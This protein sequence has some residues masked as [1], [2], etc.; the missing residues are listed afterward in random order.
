MTTWGEQLA[1]LKEIQRQLEEAPEESGRPR[2]SAHDVLRRT[3][4]AKLSES[5]G[6]ATI[7]YATSW[8]ESRP[9]P[10]NSALTINLGDIQGFMEAVS[11]IE[12]TELDLI[13]T[14]PGGSAEAAD[15][16]MGYLRT[17][18]DHIR[19]VVPVAAKSA[20]TMMALACDEIVMGEHSELGPID[21]QFTIATPE[22]PR[23]APA[24][25]IL[26]QFELAKQECRSGEN[27]A[28][29]LPLLRSL[30]PG[31]IAQCEHQR[32]LAE[33]FASTN[34]AT[35]MFAGR[36]DAVALAKETAAWFADFSA[37]KSHGRRVGLQ[38]AREQHLSVTR[39]EDDD[40]FQDLVLSVHHATRHTF[41]GTPTVKLIEN[42]RGRAYLE[43]HE[44]VRRTIGGP[45]PKGQPAPAQPRPNRAQRRA[46]K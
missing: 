36:P 37:F 2:P 17:R 10:N 12:E 29:W 8:L 46:R 18:F 16:I 39:L 33:E 5:T 24:Q 45:D 38:E 13:L 14:S 34:L 9:V 35:H 40:E 43:M 19:A 7:V 30:A 25:A 1:E 20:A 27:I 4:L 41:N 26:D 42:H 15:S 22:G 6:R 31:L 21:P 3:Y 32:Q 11:N 23:S 44:L 28:A